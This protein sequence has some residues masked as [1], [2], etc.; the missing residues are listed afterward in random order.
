MIRSIALAVAL[1]AISA[2]AGEVRRGMTQSQ[3]I[4]AVGEPSQRSSL[5]GHLQWIYI[6]PTWKDAIPFHFSSGEV[7][8]ITFNRGHVMEVQND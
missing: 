4:A 5:N 7:L 8:S 2:H 3:V 6:H 1:T